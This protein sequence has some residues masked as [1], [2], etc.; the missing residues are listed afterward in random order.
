MMMIVLSPDVQL[1]GNKIV[2][3]PSL[4]VGCEWTCHQE[5]ENG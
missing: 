1:M 4:C 2:A 5:A 3:G